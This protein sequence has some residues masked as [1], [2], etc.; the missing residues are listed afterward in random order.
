MDGLRFPAKE[1][2]PTWEVVFP[3][4]KLECNVMHKLSALAL[5]VMITAPLP[6]LAYTQEDADA[7]TPDAMKLCQA[8]IPDANRVRD[9]LVQNKRNLT[10]ACAIVMSRPHDASARDTPQNIQRTRY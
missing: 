5:I 8:A 10:S 9:C 4:P 2:L 1:H 6:A 3:P 7:C